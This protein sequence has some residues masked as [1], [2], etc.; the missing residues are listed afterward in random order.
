[1][2][3]AMIKAIVFDMGGV[4]VD[5]D[6]KACIRAFLD[7][8]GY[9]RIKELIDPYHQ[10][11]IYGELEEGAISA[12][13]FRAAVLAESRPGCTPQDVDRCMDAMISGMEPYK[14]DLLKELSQ[15]YP[16]YLLSNNNEIAR[17]RYHKIL[18]SL[19]LDWRSVFREEF[20]SFQMKLLKP[21]P[22][23]FR[24]AICRIGLPPEEILFVDDSP[25]NVEAARAV[26][27]NAVM[28]PQGGDLR[29]V[30]EGF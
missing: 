13:E 25:V 12:D 3:K 10:K 2:E 17:I 1:M 27:L 21:D 22:E 16:L 19:G 28:C 14:A 9:E 23:F 4:L 29:K 11:G 24:E 7:I 15:K 5:L 8:L 26:G 6:P 20:C 30:F 18:S